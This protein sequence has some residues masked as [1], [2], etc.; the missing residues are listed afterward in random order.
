MARHA[1]RAELTGRPSGPRRPSPAG[2]LRRRLAATAEQSVVAL[3]AHAAPPSRPIRCLPQP[4]S[5]SRGSPGSPS[6]PR[7]DPRCPAACPRRAR[8]S[9]RPPRRRRRSL[10]ATAR[11]DRSSGSAGAARTPAVRSRTRASPASTR[12]RP[13]GDVDA[14]P[15]P[16]QPRRRSTRAARIRAQ[17]RGARG[18]AASGS[19]H[20]RPLRG[21]SRRSA[22]AGRSSVGTAPPGRARAEPAGLR[23]THPRA[24]SRPR[25]TGAGTSARLAPLSGFAA[26][27][28]ALRPRDRRLQPSPGDPLHR[29]GAGDP[30]RPTA[31]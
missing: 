10:P 1:D 9:R 15:P 22:V 23:S 17:R 29:P 16:I 24:S 18:R 14:A 6:R 31:G 19:D 4:A 21:R 2:D 27:I 5:P 3:D 13:T 12:D 30:P 7:R 20:R 26:G 11:L 8:V 25:S 28:D